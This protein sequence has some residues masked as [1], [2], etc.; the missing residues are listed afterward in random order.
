MTGIMAPVM[1][2][3]AAMGI[4]VA[5]W[6]TSQVEL[7]RTADIAAWAGAANYAQNSNAQKA[8]G[9]AANLAR[10]N[11][12]AGGTTR[13][14]SN[15]TKTLVDG[16]IRVDLVAGLRDAHADA[17]K[18]TVQR[19]LTT[20]FSRIFPGV[21]VSMTITAETVAEIGVV[22]AGPQP[23]MTA[24]GEGVDGITTGDD[25]VFSGNVDVT[26]TGCSIR[27]NSG[28]RKNGNGTVE[29]DAGIYAG[30]TISGIRADNRHEHAGQIPDPYE[31]YAPVQDAIALLNPGSGLSRTVQS[32]TASFNPANQGVSSSWTVKGKLSLA[33]GRYIV[34]GPI[35]IGAGAEITGTGVTIVTSGAVTID[36]HATVTLTAATTA[37]VSSGAIPGVVFAGTSQGTV[38]I[39]G[40]STTTIT[41]LVYFPQ[42]DLSFSGTSD[43]GTTGCLQV[44]ASTIKVVGTTDL[45]S[46]CDQYGLLDYGSLPATKTVALVR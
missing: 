7:Q 45:A 18:V 6:S 19:A 44:I 20:T 32:G 27:S 11:G 28:I 46:N 35:S 8:T 5:W 39:T 24:L 43:A 31:D 12:V 34:N 21:G 30:G 23:C 13:S 10:L 4:E 38:K 14:W 42:G 1:L 15:A 41:G 9:T 3:S 25:A 2:M 26:L 37:N 40:N 33:P 17:V 16:Q 29:A 22:P 36:G